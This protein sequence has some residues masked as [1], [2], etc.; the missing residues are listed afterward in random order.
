MRQIWSPDFGF[1]KRTAPLVVVILEYEIGAPTL[2]G[3]S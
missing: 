1:M 2:A 3:L